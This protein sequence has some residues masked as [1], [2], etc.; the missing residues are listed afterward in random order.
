MRYRRREVPMSRVD[1]DLVAAITDGLNTTSGE[2]IY[3]YQ[4]AERKIVRDDGL[5]FL[6]RI[7]KGRLAIRGY[8][9]GL[10]QSIDYRDR[11][12]RT[13]I[14][15]SLNKSPAQIA[16]DIL[17]RLLPV[18][19]PVW[20]RAKEAK[21]RDD[22]YIR[23]RNERARALCEILG[24]QPLSHSPESVYAYNPVTIRAEVF[25]DDVNISLALEYSDAVKLFKFI[26][27]TVK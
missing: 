26:K 23:V 25:G 15:V 5:S 4:V 19:E 1:I 8:F 27:A 21:A 10:W 18:F 12:V 13:D 22:E 2:N 24:A 9:G 11:E 6:L 17:G 20:K 14:T 16:K 3:S 7:E